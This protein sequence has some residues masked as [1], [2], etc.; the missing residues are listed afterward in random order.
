VN[1][2]SINK[3]KTLWYLL[4]YGGFF[5]FLATTDPRKLS[6]QLLILPFL[7]LFICLFVAILKGLRIASFKYRSYSTGKQYGVALLLSAL[8]VCA[9]LLKSIG[10]LTVRDSLLLFSLIVAGGLYASRLRVN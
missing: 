1:K 5:L 9:L 8:P 6:L 3:K 4:L 10:Q 2:K 7:W